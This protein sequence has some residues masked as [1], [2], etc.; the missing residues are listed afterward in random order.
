MRRC[1]AEAS[2]GPISQALRDLRTSLRL[3]EGAPLPTAP[4]LPV[5][6]A[7]R[8]LVLCRF[9][10]PPD[11]ELRSGI[12]PVWQ[13]GPMHVQAGG[14]A[15]ARF[16]YDRVFGPAACQ[17]DVYAP[18]EPIVLGAL[19]G[20][21]GAVL[22]YGQTS[23]GKTFT[24][25]GPRAGGGPQADGLIQRALTT[26]FD[27][28]SNAAGPP[29]RIYL[30]MLEIYMEHFRDLLDPDSGAELQI[31]T[32]RGG[33]GVRV[34]GLRE[35]ELGNLQDALE[36]FGR[37]QQQRSVRSTGMNDRSSRSHSVLTIRFERFGGDAPG[38]SSKLCLVDLAGSECLKKSCHRADGATSNN[39][40]LAEEARAINQSLSTLGLVMK[41]LAGRSKGVA[42]C[43]VPFRSSKLTRVLQ[44][45]LDGTSRAALIINCSSSQFQVAETLSTLRFG[46][47]TRTVGTSTSSD[48]PLASKRLLLLQTLQ[49]ARQEIE[50]LRAMAPTVRCATTQL[51]EDS[52]GEQPSTP[53]KRQRSSQLEDSPIKT[54]PPPEASRR[55]TAGRSSSPQ[56]DLAKPTSRSSSLSRA[57]LAMALRRFSSRSQSERRKGTSRTRTL[58]QATPMTPDAAEFA[59]IAS[60]E[61]LIM[62]S[63]SVFV[64]MRP[65]NSRV[66]VPTRPQAMTRVAA[67]TVSVPGLRSWEYPLSVVEARRR[68]E[69]EIK[70]EV[71]GFRSLRMPR[72]EGS[73]P[74]AVDTLP[75]FGAELQADSEWLDW[76]SAAEPTSILSPEPKRL[77]QED[78]PSDHT[79]VEDLDHLGQSGQVLPATR[80][81]VEQE[82]VNHVRQAMCEWWS[83]RLS[84]ILLHDAL[85]GWAQ[86][87][88]LHACPTLSELELRGCDHHDETFSSATSH[89]RLQPPLFSLDMGGGAQRQVR[90]ADDCSEP[91]RISHANRGALE[92]S[93]WISMQYLMPQ[94]VEVHRI[95]MTTPV[96]A[97]SS[98]FWALPGA[99]APLALKG[100]PAESIARPLLA[101]CL[102]PPLLGCETDA[103]PQ[104]IILHGW[105]VRQLLTPC[106]GQ[107]HRISTVVLGGGG[108]GVSAMSDSLLALPAEQL[109]DACASLYRVRLG[110]V[111][112]LALT[113]AHPMPSPRCL[114]PS[115]LGAVAPLALTDAPP[116]PSPRCLQRWPLGAVAPLALT[117]APSLA[118]PRCLQPLPLGPFATAVGR[119]GPLSWPPPPPRGE[120]WGVAEVYCEC[121]KGTWGVQEVYCECEEGTC[122]PPHVASVSDDDAEVKGPSANL[123]QEAS[124]GCNPVYVLTRAGAVVAVALASLLGAAE[125]AWHVWP[126]GE[127]FA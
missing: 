124:R 78:P 74:D 10:P 65:M 83:K 67:L 34:R 64:P 54:S 39:T 113:D 12:R 18:V 95:S 43:H 14:G 53:C 32:E 72:Q 4:L 49:A 94:T 112:P 21:S 111:A 99:V 8:I 13:L 76:L 69:A 121:E 55:C 19:A 87:T 118:S 59:E 97:T 88:K 48:D 85:H 127:R 117:D 31:A 104:P 103:A 123:G 122:D 47:C 42:N 11:L 40:K 2:D 77:F 33:G 61:D 100:G 126:P 30:S 75:E 84:R 116:L 27:A 120:A 82:R 119:P 110:V 66:E 9:R 3:P 89:L 102:Q 80:P 24:M 26:L 62:H 93:G 106:S 79:N 109:A 114:Q 115:P 22:C 56:C 25:E 5:G 73:Y 86:V 90:T 20:T 7:G 125:F 52:G 107:A 63:N 71:E 68:E 46:A 92:T 81:V 1:A 58:S 45:A 29:V 35:V 98:L 51:V 108:S 15:R 96:D 17:A 36:V 101:R 23:A 91:A 28:T 6:E 37:G 16:P 41:R 50:S 60:E 57:R 44:D 70:M 38:K 105:D